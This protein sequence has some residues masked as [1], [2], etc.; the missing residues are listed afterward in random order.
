LIAA[1]LPRGCTEFPEFSMFREIPEYS[2]FSRFVA[3]LYTT[4]SEEI[5]SSWTAV[6]AQAHY[7]SRSYVA[8]I[9]RYLPHGVI[10][11]QPVL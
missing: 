7:K 10:L 8:N 2:T 6:Q 1:I 4:K 5:A 11:H 3:A 9:T